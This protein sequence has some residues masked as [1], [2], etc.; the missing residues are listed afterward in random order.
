MP[1]GYTQELLDKD[2]DFKGWTMLCARAMGVCIMMRDDPLDAQIP[3]EFK[4][5]DY[6]P[7]AIKKA[8][9]KLAK[10]LKMTREQRIAWAKKDCRKHVKILTELSEKNNREKNV[11]KMEATLKET[12]A[13]KPPTKDH[14]PFKDFM[15]QQLTSSL[16][17][18]RHATDYYA[19]EAA[20]LKERTPLYHFNIELQKTRKDLAYHK[21]QWREE[22]QR[23]EQ[24]NRWIRKLR[25][26]LT[27]LPSTKA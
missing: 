1:T 5:G 19:Q 20:R 12:Q 23:V 24:R 21:K 26:S 25:D 10:L 9:G 16:D 3:E 2:L 8:E 7:K 27:K 14:Q 6:H 11:A 15:I 18:E 17:S 22:V 13:W 4:P